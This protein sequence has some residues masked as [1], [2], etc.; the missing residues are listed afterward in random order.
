MISTTQI[1]SSTNQKL[2]QII[3][4]NRDYSS[5]NII[6]LESN[7]KIEY[8]LNPINEKLF[9]KDIFSF[10]DNKNILIESPI[11][12]KKEIPGILILEDNKT[13]GRTQNKK[14]LYYKCIPND[15][16]LPVFL[17]PYEIQLGFYKVQKNRYVTFRYDSW[18]DKHPHGVLVQNLGTIDT[19]EI[20]YE[21]QLYCNDLHISITP[22][23]K[24]TRELIE[25][26]PEENLIQQILE[27]PDYN[28]EDRRNT[29]H[30]FSIDPEGCVDIDDAMS[31]QFLEE[32]EFLETLSTHSSSTEFKRNSTP[33]G[34]KF[35]EISIYIANVVFWLDSFQL[36]DY[37]TE[38]ISTIYMP[39]RK[40]PML[41][42]LLS[43]NLCS[44]QKKKDRLAFTMVIKVDMKGVIHDVKIINSIIHVKHNYV[45]EEPIL[46]KNPEYNELKKITQLMDPNVK[47]SHDV[48]TFWMIF[49]NSHCGELLRTKGK[50]IFRSSVFYNSRDNKN[51]GEF[52]E[53]TNR[54]LTMWNNVSGEY[55]LYEDGKDLQHDCLGV[56]TYVH[57]TSPIRRLVDTINQMII[58]KEYDLIKKL[59]DHGEQFIENWFLKIEKINN[60][61][62]SIRKVQNDCDLV[63]KCFNN[64]EIMEREYTGIILEKKKNDNGL[65]I[66]SVYL[67]ELK[68]ISRTKTKMDILEFSIQKV[69]I[70]LFEEEE[71]KERKIRLEIIPGFK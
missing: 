31:I 24:K 60:I 54:F 16:K 51:L 39:D 20:Y 45:Y 46:I 32:D 42:N 25:N 59:S 64:P 30:V 23:I 55:K 1:F 49:M 35:L 58:M 53:E 50:G 41:P 47:D 66:Y 40:R 52:S 37:L 57:I 4:E 65:F 36:W 33:N 44:L 34:S 69:K 19:L 22:L 6:D 27:N 15:K 12:N 13:F 28:I 2:S 11:R 17:V 10:F 5:W 56:K 38:R 9:S 14:R 61:M 70:Y 43:E 26:I 63:Y 68:M 3:I 67:E 71:K 29:H 8:P 7:T 48:V 21:Y 62:K 18:E